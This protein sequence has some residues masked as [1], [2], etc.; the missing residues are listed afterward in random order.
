MGTCSSRAFKT[1]GQ[2]DQCGQ[3]DEKMFASLAF[4]DG[5]ALISWTR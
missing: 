4:L 1:N 2:Q 3:A 5:G